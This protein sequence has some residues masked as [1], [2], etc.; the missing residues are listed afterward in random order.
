MAATSKKSAKRK[1]AKPKKP[2]SRGAKKAKPPTRGRKPRTGKAWDGGGDPG[3]SEITFGDGTPPTR[4]YTVVQVLVTYT[5]ANTG[6]IVYAPPCDISSLL[7]ASSD[8]CPA[9]SFPLGQTYTNVIAVS[10]VALRTDWYAPER[11]TL[12][13]TKV[14]DSYGYINTVTANIDAA[15]EALSIA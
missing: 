11:A 5:D 1:P 6:L 2:A 10:V 8:P 14:W 3:L 4:L 12:V 7:P 15:G 13:A 9:T